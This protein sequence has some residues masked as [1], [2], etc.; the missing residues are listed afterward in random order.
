MTDRLAHAAEKAVHWFFSAVGL[1]VTLIPFRYSHVRRD[2][3]AYRPVFLPWLAQGEFSEIYQV[4]KNQTTLDKARCY[5]LYALASQAVHAE[6]AIWECGVYRG[7]TA[8]LLAEL[9]KRHGSSPSDGALRL[10]DTF[11]GMPVSD[12]EKDTYRVDSFAD[13]SYEHVAKLVNDFSFVH[14]HKGTIPETF[15]GLED[16]KISF[17]HI[18]VD[19]YQSVRDCLE[20][21]YPRLVSG[22]VIVLD[23]YGFAGCYG[24][25]EAVDEYFSGRP[26][27]P[28]ALQTGQ[29]V[30]TKLSA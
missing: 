15:L 29:A 27:R 17:A 5:T 19:Q 30:V 2:R 3:Y 11:E 1:P 7:G 6:G 4:I 16:E 21:I 8:L 18:D 24:A 28:L 25:R 13:T 23:D 10:F 26:E 14:L 9:R 12:P 22:G 20:F